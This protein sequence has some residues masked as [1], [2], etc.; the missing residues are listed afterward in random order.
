LA[1]SWLIRVLYATWAA[2]T[3]VA[4]AIRGGLSWPGIVDGRMGGKREVFV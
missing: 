1:A 4:Q 3:A 2:G